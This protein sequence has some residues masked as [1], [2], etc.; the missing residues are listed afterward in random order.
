MARLGTVALVMLLAVASVGPAL[1]VAAT[2]PHDGQAAVVQVG[3][4]SVDSTEFRITVHRNASARW[5]FLYETNLNNESDRADFE[6]YADRFNSEE[7]ELYTN[8]RNRSR[9]ITRQGSDATGREMNATGFAKR[10][11][12]DELTNQGVVRMSFRWTAFA[13]QDGDAV[14]MGDVF[15]GGFYIAPD[16]RLLV[17]RGPELRFQDA[18]PEPILDEDTLAESDTLTWRGERE[19]T[20]ER[21]RVRLVPRSGPT[22]TATPTAATGDSPTPTPGPGGSTGFLPILGLAVV[23]L[24]GIGAALA[25]RAGAL[26]GRDADGSAGAAAESGG[27][28]DT[29]DGGDAAAAAGAA[30]AAAESDEQPEPA[31]P[32]EELLEDDE[33]VLRLLDENGGRMKQVDIVEETGWSKSKVS[34][35]LSDMEDGGEISKLRVGRENIISRKGMEP[36]AAGSPFDD[37]E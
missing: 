18:G 26:P 25:Y 22:P 16:Q 24:L 6:A 12:V 28:G 27:G 2:A 37:G 32:D 4:Q 13:A 20:D 11:F 17:N 31:V 9:S 5:A 7:T 33:R 30:G 34:M 10:A 15:Q 1:G 3:N 29:G 14:V 36:D 21:P 8:F 23:V 19:F 35:L